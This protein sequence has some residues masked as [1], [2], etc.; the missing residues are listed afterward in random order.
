MRQISALPY[1][2]RLTR[3]VILFSGILLASVFAQGMTTGRVPFP[4]ALTENPTVVPKAEM[5]RIY[6]EVRTPFK[7]GVILEGDEGEVLDCPNVFRHGDKWYMMFV[8]NKDNVGY[9]THL[10]VSDDLLS[11]KRLGKILRFADS[12]WDKWQAD[13]GVALW[14]YE[15]GGSA[16]LG[17]FEDRY[18]LTY[19]GGHQQG[20]EPDPL[21]TGL[22]STDDPTQ[23]R[24]WTRYEGNPILT[25]FQDGVRP[26]EVKTI[27]KT[28]V[29]HDPEERLGY[30]FIMYYNGKDGAGSGHEA[31]GMAVSNDMRN[32]IRMGDTHLI[33]NVG[34]LRWSIS[35]DPQIVRIG[36][37]WVMF[38]FGA[39]WEP[40]AFDT[41]AASYDLVNWTKWTGTHLIQP[42]EPFDKQF[43]H[44]PWL[45]KHDG[46]VYH[47]YCS[48]GDSGR[49]IALA[50]SK[51]LGR[52]PLQ[53]DTLRSVTFDQPSTHFTESL[54]LGN[55]RLGAMISGGVD[56]DRIVL[57]ENG[58]WSG[59]P[60]D[61]DRS[62]AAEA[63]PEIRRLLLE[64]RNAEAEALVN[65]HF[66]C[67][68]EGS[69]LGLG[70]D[71]PYGSYQM[72]GHLEL[73]FRYPDKLGSA[74]YTHYKRSLRLD[75]ATAV[76]RFTRGGIDFTR[77]AFISAPD[78]VFVQRYSATEEGVISFDARL[79]RPE[80]AQIRVLSE[81]ELELFGELSNGRA[82]GRGTQFAARLKVVAN[83]GSVISDGD[84]IQVRGAD[85]VLLFVT[86]AT[87]IRT[88]AG[89]DVADPSLVAA[90]D[91]EQALGK[92]FHT[93]RRAHM[94]DYQKLFGR[95]SLSL[96][97]TDS[98]VQQLSTGER[99]RRFANG[100]P[101]PDLAALYFDYGRYLLISASRPGGLP[102]NLQGIWADTLQ[103]PWNGDWHANINVQMNYWP[104]EVTHLSELHEPLFALIESLSTHGVQTAQS[105]FD[106]PGWVTFLLA[107]PWGFTSPGESARWG[108][109]VSCSAWLC[110]HLWEHYRYTGD[111]EFLERSYPIL[112][113]AAEF[114]L[115]MLI[116]LPEKGWLVTSPSN[117]PENA[118]LDEDGNKVHVCMGPTADMQ[119]LRFLFKA[120][121]EAAGIL[122][123]DAAFADRLRAVVPQLAP[124]QIGPDGR[125]MEWLEP[126]PEADPQHRHV[127]HL[128]GLYPGEE[129]D[130]VLTP[131]LAAAARQT[132][133]RRGDGSTGWSVAFKLAMWARLGDGDRA[134]QLL[135]NLL[136]PADQE[137]AK[138]RWSGGTFANLF[139]SHPPF[140][141]DGNFG[142]TAAIAEM[143]LQSHA[144]ELRLL[145][146]LPSAWGTGSVKGL[147]ARGGISLEIDWEDGVLLR[148]TLRASKEQSVAIR[149][150]SLLKEIT[151]PARKK[152]VLSGSGLEISE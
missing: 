93:L 132:L 146:A 25:P 150:G 107:N 130:P 23:A 96:E 1:R 49:V 99:L 139:C 124:T 14:D 58:M 31:I 142:A 151:L 81:S 18:W 103:T 33:Y 20:Y 92:S 54:P 77:E 41:F 53:K 40:G 129:I 16:T 136:K 134:H 128:W 12:G 63:L 109:T 106:A 59:S 48:V 28:H 67:A 21:S 98:E 91:L 4:K 104:A 83:G 144:G 110:H 90:V 44:K 5:Q 127:A 108:S 46:V 140:Q 138:V 17:T 131:H 19:I 95:V 29:I 3:L 32:W 27:Y 116:E 105:Y 69:G 51:D 113:G 149:Y 24:D 102:A 64:G 42:S 78:N 148:T 39:F 82:S 38:Y 122:Q 30:P 73:D 71:K 26:F 43:A 57:N 7:Y 101:D 10:A 147:R 37:L 145:P 120:C 11:W 22:A 94:E 117:S 13:A 152:V 70:A 80:R 112:K 121:I 114:Y 137:T 133:D 9:E 135:G 75:D 34:E 85:S 50:T 56:S 47:F 79:S 76:T 35:G 2:T 6:E 125:I 72:L 61:A 119:L 52:S 118:F 8:V 45:L 62:G 126:Y 87:D 115:S 65:A 100:Q 60:Q 68:G 74:E 89:R 143:L 141:I 86:A 123:Q 15:W 111:L 88:F 36:D 84:A 55:G 97:G 66:T